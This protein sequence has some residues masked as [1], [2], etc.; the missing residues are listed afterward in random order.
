MVPFKSPVLEKGAQL[1]SLAAVINRF[2]GSGRVVFSLF[3]F[4]IPPPA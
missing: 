1:F 3:S 4:I 2:V